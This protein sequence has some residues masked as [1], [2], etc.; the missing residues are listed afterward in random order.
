[1]ALET[2][3]VQR[4][5]DIKVAGADESLKHIQA[6]NRAF[7]KMDAAKKKLNQQLEKK[8]AAGDTK[9]ISDLTAKITE[10]EGKLKNLDKQRQQSA[11]EMA[12][13]A[14]A[15]KDLASADSIRTKSLIDQEKE[16]DRK[17]ALEQKATKTSAAAANAA[18][19]QGSN[20]YALVQNLKAA[21]EAYKLYDATVSGSKGLDKV[22]QDAIDAKKAV[23]NFNRSL[24]PD[25]TLVGEYKTGIINAFSKLGLNDV[26][27]KQKN[28]LQGELNQ[29][30]VTNQKLANQLKVVGGTGTKAFKDIESQLIN[31]LQKQEDIEGHLKNINTTLNQTGNIGSTVVGALSN[32]FKNLKTNIAQMV[33]GY[34]G[35]QAVISSTATA[36]RS[37][38]ELSDK[39][40]DLQRVLGA[41]NVEFD[42]IKQNL[43]DINTRTSLTQLI[44]FATIAA[45]AGVAKDQISS[46]TKS[47]DQLYLVAGKSLGD[48][49][50]TFES[51][52][53]LNTIFNN[54]APVTGEN[55]QKLGN[56]LVTLDNAGVASG[57]FLIDFAQRLAGIQGVTKIQIQSVLGLAAAFQENGASAEVAASASSQVIIK[58]ASDTEKYARI[59]GLTKQAFEDLI[60]SN[61]GEA[62][63]QVA[64]G[65]KGNAK[66][67]TEFANNFKELDA[68][69]VRVTTVMGTLA[70]K[71]EFFRQKIALAN[72]ALQSNGA[73]LAGADAKNK[74]FGAT[75]DKIAGQF[76]RLA[77]SKPFIATM[78]AIAA[79]VLL[80][81]GNLPTLITILGLYATGWAIANK[82][83]I[84]ARAEL[85]FQR[86]IMPILTVLFGGQ[87]N[88]M[89]AY[90]FA[91]ELAGKGMAFLGKALQNPIFRIFSV[92]LGA[93]VV[94]IKAF[95]NGI[96]AALPF[97]DKYAQ[98][99]AFIAEAQ[100]TASKS[101]SEIQAKEQLLLS[102]IRDRSLADDVRQR[103]L[104]DLIGLMGKYGE[105]LTLENVLTEKGTNALRDFNK[106]LA[107]KAQL[108]AQAAIAQREQNK[109]QTL[110]QYQQDVKIA[111]QTKGSVDTKDFD[112]EFLDAFYKYTG[113]SASAVGQMIGEKLG[114]SFTYSGKDLAIFKKLI[115]QRIDQQL[116]RAVSAKEADL[117]L[118]SQLGTPIPAGIGVATNSAVK[119]AE[120]DLEKLQNDIDAVNA[121]IKVFKGTQK[122]LN[123]LIKRRD[124]LQKKYDDLTNK[125]KPYKGAR[126]SG[127]NKDLIADIDAE[128]DK[129]LAE[130]NK[131]RLLN[132]VTEEDHLNK[133]KD[134]QIRAIDDKLK[135]IKGANA[136]E[137]K[138]IAELQL[139]RVNIIQ[140]TED[141]L[142]N[143][144]KESYQRQLDERLRQADDARRAV[145]DDPASLPLQKLQAERQY[146]ETAITAQ[147]IFNNKMDALE[148]NRSKRSIEEE[149][150]RA[151]AIRLIALAL[152]KVRYEIDKETLEQQLRKVNEVATVQI[153][154]IKDWVASQTVQILDNK[155]LS[156][157]QKSNALSDL[158]SSSTTSILAE[159]VAQN[160]I[161]LKTIKEQY[162]AGLI[163]EEEYSNARTK[164]AESQAALAKQMA[165][166]EQTYFN[167]M[168]N[169]I[170]DI[171]ENLFGFMKKS[172]KA[173]EKAESTQKRI[174]DAIKKGEE[175]IT[176]AIQ[177]AYNNYWQAKRNQI[178]DELDV[179]KQR[180]DIQQKQVEATAQSEAEKSSIQ[181]Q[182]DYKR[183]QAEKQ[184]AEERK[185]LVLTQMTIEF[186][187]AVIKTLA[188]YI[189]PYSLIPVAGLTALYLANRSA[190]Q[191]AKYARGGMPSEGGTITGPS[192]ANGGVP[193]NAEAEGGETYIINRNSSAS[194]KRIG[195]SGTPRQIASAINAFG[196][197]LNF[198]PGGKLRKLEYGGMLGRNLSAPVNPQSYLNGSGNDLSEVYRAIDQQTKN[199]TMLAIQTNQRIDNIKVHVLAQEVQD[200]NN[201][202]AKARSIATI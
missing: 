111:Q 105:G 6:I 180:L 106:E 40:V 161:A 70:A 190:A 187:L 9:A 25:G 135:I 173:A 110:Y 147:A 4:V 44:D 87:A 112:Q 163:T 195:V 2:P 99:Q 162:D 41:T 54:N 45:K 86:T 193:F 151:Q 16:L 181:S 126:I 138:L 43:R 78:N 95:G 134:I 46:V 48:P 56:A 168:G 77:S 47:L 39:F 192:H 177:T 152:S 19:A 102:I 57:Q 167:Q 81:I 55:L 51:L 28:D 154:E 31:N 157:N 84:I 49:E 75:V 29:I 123:D 148:A 132:Q 92:I 76:E 197:G 146:Q 149:K 17:I 36:I 176:Q 119:Q 179:A 202:R 8:L 12:L 101:L 121:K 144:Q 113:R 90:A 69:G 170:K 188:S 164:L 198:A 127:E 91:S 11:K 59:A 141:K 137:R 182:Y 201:K 10:L 42:S 20:Y 24:S 124:D 104:N 5:Y 34:I 67:A 64:S 153:N 199:L 100:R 60:N 128:R 82:Q 145:V 116:K 117:D 3:L 74:T 136:A 166:K 53:K 196:G 23:D 26:L 184:A 150:K 108:E 185:K 15:M 156:N 1:M 21:L 14:K 118:Q 109:L 97:M 62:L 94:A 103:S 155:K 88:A 129:Q 63:L 171:V 22:M 120:I 165:S 189:F 114:I 174:N 27:N 139:D 96:N 172:D 158:Q 66:E 122:E 85:I 58:L 186:G 30:V 38:A 80:V 83:M 183:K 169:L 68:N 50:Q 79:A 7:D 125:S 178:D 89:K 115:E 142:Y 160:E 191:N 133:I 13:E 65:L 98:K 71:T 37:N 143:L 107:T 72:G 200:V 175:Y 18:K 131:Y 61:P 32:E 52:V 33:V 73:I 93:G 35:F 159:Q 194:N 130:E 140:E